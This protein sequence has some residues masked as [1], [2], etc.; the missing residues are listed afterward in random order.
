MD[1]LSA[2]SAFVSVAQCGSF[3]EAGVQL[4]MGPSA[5]TKKVAALEKMLGVRLLNR[6]THGVAL[7]DEGA[8]CL[9]RSIRLLAEMDG[10]EQLLAVRRKAVSGLL[11][12][13]VPYAMGQVYLAPGLPAFLARNPQLSLQLNYSDSAPDL[14][15]N[16]LDL[17]IRIGAPRDSRIM[18]RLLARSRRVTCASPAYLTQ[19]GEPAT[20]ADLQNHNCITLLRNGRK[21]LWNF[22]EAG[23][24]RS[25]L[26]PGNL[27]VNSGSA[28]REAV[29]AGLG[30]VQC[31]SILIAP[32]LRSG[33]LV[34]LLETGEV[35]SEALYAVYLQNR[36]SAP[37]L[38]AMVD[39]VAEA[40]KPFANNACEM[41]G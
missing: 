10:I 26:P 30:V 28:L 34:S 1:K 18:A 12:V 35:Q 37:R 3:T 6:T 40:F 7:T 13:S 29:I 11:R 22:L 4:A 2:I 20:V 27:S 16:S 32:E 9:E 23:R 19:L 38:Q 8:A 41:G 15:E 39:F 36:H 14:V 21:R 24:V 17:A 5:I 31:N 25:V 33:R